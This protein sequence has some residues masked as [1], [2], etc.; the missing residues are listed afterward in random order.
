MKKM[1]AIKILAILVFVMFM[2]T[3]LKDAVPGLV[4]GWNEAGDSQE[5]VGEKGTYMTDFSVKA[6]SKPVV[7]DSLVNKA[8]DKKV[9]YFVTNIRTAVK[10]P[11]WYMIYQCGSALLGLLCIYGFYCMARVVFSA[12][13]SNV[14]TRKN[15]K[16]MRLFIYSVVSFGGWLEGGYYFLY[17][18]WTSQLL[19]KGYEMESYS[20]KYPWLTFFILALFIEIFAVGVKLKE[21]QELTI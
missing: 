3:A 21:E 11:S 6:V 13:R 10:T 2:V 5:Y 15:V 8:F 7:E 1:R 20:M 18:D 17:R 4:D 14:F 9:P 12:I 16:R 19:L